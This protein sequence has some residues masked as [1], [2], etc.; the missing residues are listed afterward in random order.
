MT[1]EEAEKRYIEKFGGFPYFLFM[2]A[3]KSYI[4]PYILEALETGKE[5]EPPDDDVIY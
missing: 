1:Y 3:E 2:G 4:L 5:I